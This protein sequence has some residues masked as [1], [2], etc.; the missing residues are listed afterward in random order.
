MA[1][2]LIIGGAQ[3][4]N[5]LASVLGEIDLFLR[6]FD[7]HAQGKGLAYK[8]CAMP[9]KQG[10]QIPGAMPGGKDQR[11]RIQIMLAVCTGDAHAPQYAMFQMQAA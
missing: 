2:K 5:S 8:L 7:A 10:K 11:I 3:S 6:V 1:G 4:R 9:V